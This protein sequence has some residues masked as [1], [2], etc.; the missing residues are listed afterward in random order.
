MQL[1][2]TLR[3]NWKSNNLNH[4]SGTTKKMCTPP[5]PLISVSVANKGLTAIWRVS[6]ANK[7]LSS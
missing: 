3:P 5:T 4:L 7:G 6:V 2:I 1:N